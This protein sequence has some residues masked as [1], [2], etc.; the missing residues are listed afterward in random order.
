MKAAAPWI[1]AAIIVIIVI[2]FMNQKAKAAA[3]ATAPSLNQANNAGYLAGLGLANLIGNTH[4]GKNGNPPCN[5]TDLHN[6]GWSP[7]QV[8]S[9]QQASTSVQSLWCANFGVN[10]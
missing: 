9:A 10:C 7:E 6:A 8:S 3:T 2:Y 5:I 1:V 4:C